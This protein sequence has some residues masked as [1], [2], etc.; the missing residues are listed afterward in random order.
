MAT[1]I[2][3]WNMPGYLPN[4]EPEEFATRTEAVEYLRG[5]VGQWL[6]EDWEE[7]DVDSLTADDIISAEGFGDY[8]D[9]TFWV[10][11]IPA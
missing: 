9:F 1:Y 8:T 6:D 11:E 4:V 10:E 7:P 3:G 5:I 2:A